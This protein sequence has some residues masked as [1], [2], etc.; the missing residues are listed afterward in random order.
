MI[1]SIGCFV[2]QPSN[3]NEHTFVIEGRTVDMEELRKLVE[4]FSKKGGKTIYCTEVLSE[5]YQ[6]ATVFCDLYPLKQA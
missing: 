1:S 6:G 2:V 5:V 4:S 3:K